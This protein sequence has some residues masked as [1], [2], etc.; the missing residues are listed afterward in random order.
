MAVYFIEKGDNEM[1]GSIGT[2]FALMVLI[3]ITVLLIDLAI[4]GVQS[5]QASNVASDITSEAERRGGITPG[6][7]AYAEKRLDETGLKQNGYTVSYNT[8]GKVNRGQE[9]EI[10]VEGQ[11]AFKA[12]NFLNTGPPK[13]AVNKQET[14]VSEI[15]LR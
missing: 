12:I 9:F 4:Y 3:P 5:I 7:Q 13:L 1:K 2:L 8:I 11:Y 15:W 14:G 10:T 6:L